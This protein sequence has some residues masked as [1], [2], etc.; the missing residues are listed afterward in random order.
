MKKYIRSIFAAICF[1]IFGIGGFTIGT[2]ILPIIFILT[3]N[4]DKRKILFSNFVSLSWKF[5]VFIMETFGLIN[6]NLSKTARKKL[7]KIEGE[8]IVANHPSLID[9][10][11]LISLT[12]KPIC[13]VKGNLAK[14]FFMKNIIA[15]AYIKN[16]S[17]SEEMILKS[18]E[19]LKKGF[20]LIIFPEGT[21]TLPNHTHKLQRGAAYIAIETRCNILPIKISPSK[22]IL[23]KHQKWHEIGKEI[24]EYNLELKS[25]I[26][27]NKIID[28]TKSQNI[29]ARKLTEVIKNRLEI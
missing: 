22:Q 19:Y 13:I 24:I 3:F 18:K 8:I 2:A 21:R 26:E 11:I 29:N 25:E 7:S 5:F 4:N 20:N 12:N 16:D 6:V 10:V 27:T 17:S 9:I 28:K 1:T 23:G 15:Y 14:N